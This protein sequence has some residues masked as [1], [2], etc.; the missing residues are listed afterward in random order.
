MNAKWLAGVVALLAAPALAQPAA[1]AAGGSAAP[2]AR[3]QIRV[4]EG[5]LESAVQHGAQNL[6]REM[7]R[8]SPDVAFFSGPARARGFRLDGYGVFFALDVPALH[9]SMTWSVRTLTQS[10]ADVSRA[11]QAIR[12]M[13]QAQSDTRSKA[14]LEQAVRLLELQVRPGAP[15]PAR[16]SAAL[17]S[18]PVAEKGGSAERA[19]VAALP[20]ADDAPDETGLPPAIVSNP[21]GAYTDAVQSAIVD[22]MLDYGGTLNL[23]GEE[24]L[25]VAARENSDAMIAGD[26][27]DSVTITLRVKGADL[28]ALKSGRISRDELRRRVDVRQF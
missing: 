14:E 15:V 13:V 4:M 25:T 2:Q 3:F 24:W 5:V 27:T 12:R 17:P 26:L 1:D 23:G 19:A 10:N 16:A 7:R 6:S 22:A 28:E 11:L 21:D 9:R 20:A 8:V 18:S